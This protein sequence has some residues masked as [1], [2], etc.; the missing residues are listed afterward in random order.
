MRASK[1]GKHSP[2]LEANEDI[3]LNFAGPLTN[4]WGKKYVLVWN[5]RFSKFQSVQ[6]P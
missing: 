2:A 4:I 3:E 5:D 6:V 1:T